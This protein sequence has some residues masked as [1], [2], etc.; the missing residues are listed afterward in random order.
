MKEHVLYV[1]KY[2]RPFF[3]EFFLFEWKCETKNIIYGMT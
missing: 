2:L 3:K 1:R